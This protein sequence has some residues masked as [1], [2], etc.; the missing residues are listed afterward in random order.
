MSRESAYVLVEKTIR[1]LNNNYR[2]QPSLE[3]IA[4]QMR[5]SPYHLHRTFTEWAG[6]SPKKF[7]QHLTVETLKA[8]LHHSSNLIEAAEKVGLSSQSRV[9]DLFVSLEAVTPGEYKSKGQGMVIEYGIHPSPFGPCFI[10]VTPRGI[11]ALN[12]LSGSP[13]L[14]M[15]DLLDQWESAVIQEN[16][17][18]TSKLIRK[19]FNPITSVGSVKV[20]LKGTSFQV[21]VWEALLKIPFGKVASYQTIAKAT[22]QPNASRAVGTAV[23]HNP[24]AFLI[25]CHRVIRSEGIVGN[26]RWDSCRKAAIIGWEKTFIVKNEK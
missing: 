8:E 25:P 17:D 5:L 20:L 12:F 23:A 21:K 13:E 26:Y 1:Y 15:R 14:A 4:G 19:I 24:V 9:Y 16:S 2:D 6:I 7:L 3:E 10:A 22:G 11:C 18:L